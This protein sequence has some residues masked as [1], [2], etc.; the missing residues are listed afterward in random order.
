ML[1]HSNK[2]FVFVQ[3]KDARHRSA[4]VSADPH[5]PLLGAAP[6][7]GVRHRQLRRL[8][9]IKGTH[10]SSASIGCESVVVGF[11]WLKYDLQ[12]D[13]SLVAE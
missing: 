10:S 1:Q 12:F 11:C 8:C 5:T 2:L 6:Q 7:L 3:G 9:F 4:R 13:C